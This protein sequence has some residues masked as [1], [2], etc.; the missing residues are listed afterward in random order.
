MRSKLLLYQKHTSIY[1]S[2]D[3][4]AGE[5]DVLALALLVE[6]G[7]QCG[8]EDGGGAE[9]TGGRLRS[10]VYLGDEGILQALDVLASVGV[11]V[12]EVP[13]ESLL[14][15]G[16][17]RVQQGANFGDGVGI[18]LIVAVL[19]LNLGWLLAR[20][21]IGVDDGL[22]RVWDGVAV[23]DRLVQARG[24]GVAACLVGEGP[25]VDAPSVRRAVCIRMTRG[26]NKNQ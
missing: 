2:E 4:I 6:H 16:R 10:D 20:H 25:E 14:A 15:L 24:C 3:I 17:G 21:A 11:A 9:Y 19:I 1:S 18:G 22:L 7:S 5:A 23:V 26:S 8:E 12:R 13:L